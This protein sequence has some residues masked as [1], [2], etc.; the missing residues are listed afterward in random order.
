MNLTEAAAKACEELTLIDA[1]VYI[2]VW[3]TERIVKQARAN[4]TWETCFKV[5]FEEV[6]KEWF[7]RKYALPVKG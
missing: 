2:S 1:L 3:E 6:F 4:E 5:S 7:K